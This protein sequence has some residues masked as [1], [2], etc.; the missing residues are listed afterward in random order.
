MPIFTPKKDFFS[1]IICLAYR[2]KNLVRIFMLATWRKKSPWGTNPQH[3]FGRGVDFCPCYFAKK[4][5]W[6][7]ISTTF[8]DL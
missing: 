7:Q 2:Y 3:V 8:L 1:M 6:A 4:S 5:L